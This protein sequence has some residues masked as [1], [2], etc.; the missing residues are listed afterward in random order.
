MILPIIKGNK[1]E[2]YIVGVKSCSPEFS[3]VHV[4]VKNVV[5]FYNCHHQQYKATKYANLSRSTDNS[6]QPSNAALTFK[7][8]NAWST[9]GKEE[10]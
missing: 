10:P 2:G 7:I 9:I 4:G 1:L 6:I 3:Q 5:L 8:K